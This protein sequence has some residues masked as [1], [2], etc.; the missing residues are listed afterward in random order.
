MNSREERVRA[1]LAQWRDDLLDLTGRNRLL[2]FRHTKTASL[3]V[4]AP[5]AQTIL[6]RLV[7]GRSREWTF[8]IPP[9]EQTQA[10]DLDPTAA[11][12]ALGPADRAPSTAAAV[13]EALDRLAPGGDVHVSFGVLHWQ[14]DGTHAAALFLVPAEI[15]NR[16]LRLRA[17]ELIVNPAV[18]AHFQRQFE[19]DLGEERYRIESAGIEEAFNH[20]RTQLEPLS[21]RIDDRIGILSSAQHK[22][23]MDET[24]DVTP[25]VLISEGPR[26]GILAGLAGTEEG[27][28]FVPSKRRVLGVPVP[29]KASSS[30][31]LLMTT[32]AA[33][34]D[35]RAACAGLARR[36][37]TEFMDRGIW[38]LYLG[39]GMLHWSDPADGRAEYQDSPLLLVPVR[40]EAGKGGHDWK[41]ASTEEE[42]LVNPAL[43]LK[44]ETELGIELPELDPEEPLEVA[45]LLAQIRD[46]VA[47]HPAW[48]VEER[49]VLS[50]FSFHKE[51]MYR[52][53]RA[54]FEQIVEHPIVSA[55][56]AGP[57]DDSEG[58]DFAFEPVDEADL[59][60]EHKPEAAV[61]IL[62]AD[63]SQRQC[64]AAARAGRSFVM[65][66]P[67]GT[68]KSQT[69]ANMIA[70]LITHGKTVLFV[71]EKAAALDVV[72]NR[73][74]HVGLDEYTLELH[75]H[76][77][78]RAAVAGALGA[79]LVRRPKPNPALTQHDLNAAEQRRQALSRY[80]ATLNAP[81]DELSGR[82]LHHLLG[83]I[84]GLQQLP[85]AP[86]AEH[87]PASRA[88]VGELE[89]LAKQLESTWAVVERGED[90]VWR[91]AAATEWTTA[92]GQ[93]VLARLEQL[94]TRLDSLRTVAETV[95]ED[96][97]LEP[98]AGPHAARELAA[99]LVALQQRPEGIPVDW[100]GATNPG[101]PAERAAQRARRWTSATQAAAAAAG[102]RWRELDESEVAS[103]LASLEQLGVTAPESAAAAVRLADAADRLAEAA[104]AV[105]AHAEDLTPLLG[106]RSSE[107]T[108]AHAEAAVELTALAAEGSPPPASWFASPPI[109]GV[110]RVIELLETDVSARTAAQ[111]FEPSVLEL[112]LD[113]LARRFADE[114][115]GL[116]KLGGAYRADRDTLAA[117]APGVKAKQA[118]ATI[119]AAI[120]WKQARAALLYTAAS[121]SAVLADAWSGPETDVAALR[122]RLELARRAHEVAGTRVADPARFADVMSGRRAVPGAAELAGRTD[123]AAA[124]LRS[125]LPEALAPLL[126]RALGRAAEELGKA[127][128]LLRAVAAATERVDVLRGSTGSVTSAVAAATARQEVATVEAEHADDREAT[129]VLEQW[130]ALDVDPDALAAAVTSSER[131]RALLP[132]PPPGAAAARLVTVAPDPRFLDEALADWR[133]AVDQMLLE[134][135]A[136]WREQLAGDLEGDFDDASALIGTLR[137]T[138]GS[139]EVWVAHAQA[140]ERL[141]AAGLGP[142]V[143]FAADRRVPS[144][145]VVG[146]LRRSALEALADRMLAERSDVLGPL[147]SVDRDRL[148]A[149]YAR[150]DRAIVGDAAHRVMAAANARR[151]NAILGVAAI[152]QSEA[153]KKRR[154]MPV[155][156]LLA[157]TAP[158]A[159]AIKPC[160]MMS[161]LSVSQF[162]APDMR[163]DVVIFDEASQV[164]P[165]D[166][167]NAL[168]RGD[169]MIIAGDRNQLPPTSFF[170]QSSDGSDEW[171]EEAPAEY[172]S[173]LDLAKG[174]GRFRSLSLRW[175]YRSQHEHLIAFS[176][177]RFYGRDLVTFP[178]PAEH[179]EDLGVELIQVDGQYRRGTTRDNPA[180][181]YAVAERVFAH[182][183]R[184]ERSIGVVAF[185]EAQA[186]LIEEV[187]RRDERRDDPRYAE[188]FAGDR[189]TALFVKNLENVQGDERNIIVFSVGYGPDEHGKLT[190]NFGPMN[191]EGGWRRLNV[192]ITR[193]RRRVEVISSF[194]PEQLADGSR[195][196]GVDALRQYLEFAARGPVVLTVDD[197]LDEGGEPESPFE[198][199]VLQT[200][201]AMGHSV[202]AQV[203]TAGYRID[204]AVRHPDRPGHFALGIECDGAMYH[205]SRVA[206]D[207]DRL[208]EQ[209][210]NGLGWTLHRIWGPS[211]YRDRSGEEQRL[212]EAIERALLATPTRVTEQV[213]PPQPVDVVFEDVELDAPPPWAEP[214]TVAELPAGRAFDMTEVVAQGEVRQLVLHTV[215]EEAPIVDDLLARRVV[216]A[217]GTVVSEKRRRAV[218]GAVDALVQAG[219]L[220]RHGNAVCLPAQRVD[221]VRI[222]LDGEPRTQREV[223]HVPDVEL[224]E[225]ITRFVADAR[226]VTEDE[227]KQKA[228]RLFGW[229]RAGSAIQAALTRA[230]EELTRSGRLTRNGSD[231]S[232]PG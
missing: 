109:E 168:Y 51:A 201:R 154:H 152:L 189:L 173:V 20:L 116:K 68:G 150:L 47:S 225:A 80:A 162:L 146:V 197:A 227:V 94:A 130:A 86:V 230:V 64:I 75:S 122:A 104:R 136:Q 229:A 214:Y 179:A 142:S 3:E 98:P 134:F 9:D 161:P 26:D 78:T 172:D 32:K 4:S 57:T 198:V 143:G 91:G 159:Q 141:A 180:E 44:L 182:A 29:A 181:A 106:L 158:V 107:L 93:R 61:T 42:P 67:P 83:E 62:D 11:R 160:F 17:H 49:V 149:E 95:T 169:A 27:L 22:A 99:L 46:A 48:T 103:S 204:L 144:G 72:H 151:P 15:V 54:N 221:L 12:V 87:A 193:A 101:E 13:T 28:P 115:R 41:L 121:E 200:L 50:T 79:S 185:S 217:W 82:S 135:Q 195:N 6:D 145:Q 129:D 73:L 35:V 74:A 163:F 31:P 183:E 171:V 137:D 5:D 219:T 210:L 58:E 70:E 60:R 45:P 108:L 175:H 128:T 222:P 38:V 178:S 114:H 186:S 228:A 215:A 85:H 126:E 112:D 224:A 118:I 23:L 56:A 188:L 190:M 212:R 199:A 81:T 164:R 206:R 84:A 10:E 133:E 196:K 97:L 90:F 8:H 59:D 213:A 63:A 16:R 157:R 211:W 40:L 21:G 232:P 119:D 202:V 184:G 88:A 208:R 216:S 100:L 226:I 139:I 71:S 53:L 170:E 125:E 33:G 77:T 153:Q 156:H 194:A 1:Q 123:A 117:T 55:L 191:R 14:H 127:S 110:T 177:Y 203:G 111:I 187:L 218:L 205:S 147:R 36:A 89:D 43:W 7:D 176:N 2:R 174:V 207:R 18:V 220:V 140:I 76:K 120:A 132:V 223:K 30:T 39:V 25:T 92:V 113:A 131:I 231:L 19:Y 102:Q 24:L 192:A 52:D 148:I 96:L 166:A 65:D 69:I 138:R 34:K 165:C 155:S 66:G 105:T 124:R 167:V 209:V 37:T